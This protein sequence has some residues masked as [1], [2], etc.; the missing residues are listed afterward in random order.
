MNGCYV[1]IVDS[2]KMLSGKKMSFFSGGGCEAREK[3]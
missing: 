2:L 1:V 3:M